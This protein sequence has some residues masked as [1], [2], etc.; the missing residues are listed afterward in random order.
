[1]SRRGKMIEQLF[2]G[3]DPLRRIYIKTDT[4]APSS[5]LTAYPFVYNSYD[6]DWY[7]YSQTSSDFVKVCG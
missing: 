5:A 4:G 1:M 3:K 2:V 6:D 7:I